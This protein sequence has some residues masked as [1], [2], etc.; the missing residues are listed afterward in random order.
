M[1]FSLLALSAATLLAVF[2]RVLQVMAV[3]ATAG[4]RRLSSAPESVPGGSFRTS[5]SHS[6]RTVAVQDG[7]GLITYHPAYDRHDSE[8]VTRAL[9]EAVAL[10]AT[11]LRS[12]INWR[13]IMLSP[14]EV[15]SSALEWYSSFFREVRGT[16][17]LVP[18]IVLSNPAPSVAQLATARRLEAWEKYVSAV[19]KSLGGAC[20]HFQLLNEP[21]NPVFQFFSI[22]ASTVALRTAARIIRLDIPDARLA[23]N[24]LVDIWPWQ[25]HL[26]QLLSHASEAIDIVGIDLYPSTWRIGFGSG[27]HEW[28]SMPRALHKR[29]KELR[30]DKSIAICE[31]GYSTNIPLVR[32]EAAQLNYFR[33]LIKAATELKHFEFIGI[34]ELTDENSNVIVDP[35]PNFGI[36]DSRLRRKLAFQEVQ[37]LFSELNS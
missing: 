29:L 15:N 24:F 28:Y 17:G 26:E 25:P 21:N 27:Y 31:T 8:R 9:Q 6:E 16:F 2:T 14:N 13:D 1:I 7:K 36:L 22:E 10:G 18:M 35:E 3:A 23:V 33:Q 20:R 11:Y 4:V 30:F 34:Y 5:A 32:D 19:V 12:D 37:K